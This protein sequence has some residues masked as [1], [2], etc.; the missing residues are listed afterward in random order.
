MRVY[1]ILI[2]LLLTAIM[3]CVQEGAIDTD[4]PL[5]EVLEWQPEP[6]EGLICNTIE[7]I[8]FR[9]TNEDTLRAYV[10]ITDEGGLSELKIDIHNNFDCHGHRSSTQDWFVQDIIPLE[11]ELFEDWIDIPAPNNATAGKYHFGLQ[12]TDL[13]GN[14]TDRSLF[15]SIDILNLSDTLPPV[16]EWREPMASSTVQIERGAVLQLEGTL[17]DNRSLS[18]GG[19]VAIEILTRRLPGGNNITQ[20]QL[21]LDDIE[22]NQYNFSHEF[23]IPQ[24]WLREKYELRIFAY[25]G[26]RNLAEP[27]SVILDIQ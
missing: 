24:T 17:S 13:S 6:G 7:E 16:W 19:N 11:G 22:D 9:M 12:A 2:V 26:V 15:Y 25:D 27:I 1:L 21:P 23:V 4:P 14:V 5:L 18:L 8:V 3:G 20:F 10:R